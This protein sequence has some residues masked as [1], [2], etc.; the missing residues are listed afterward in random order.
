MVKQKSSCWV[1][2]LLL[3]LILYYASTIK[4]VLNFITNIVA[5]CP[6]L[7]SQIP[8]H[9]HHLQLRLHHIHKP[10]L[11]IIRILT[12]S[13]SFLWHTLGKKWLLV[14]YVVFGILSIST[15]LAIDLSRVVGIEC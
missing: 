3:I 11:H 7:R 2:N 14:G 4:I 15:L 1:T 12:E 10:P 5:V 6:P 9:H 13:M 8:P